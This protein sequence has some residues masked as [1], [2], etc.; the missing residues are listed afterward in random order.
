MK[1]KFDKKYLKVSLYVIF[2]VILIY[3]ATIIIDSIPDILSTARNLLT[4]AFHLLR[5]LIFALVF[6]YLLFPPTRFFEKLLAGRKHHFIKSLKKRRMISIVFCYLIVFGAIAGLMTGIYFMIGGQFSSNTT[7]EKIY[8]YI[9]K[10]FESNSFS[11]EEL[12]RKLESLNLPFFNNLETYISQGIVWIQ[13]FLT[14]LLNTFLSSVLSIGS[15]VFSLLVAFVLSI[16]LLYD[17]EYFIS[18]WNRMFFLFFRNSAFGKKIRVALRM[19]DDTFSNYVR[20]QLIE[21]LIVAV[22]STIALL[23]V[24]I[25]YAFLIGIISGLFNLVPYIG[26]L[27]G[28]VLAAILGLIEGGFWQ[29][30][31][32]IVAMVIVQQLDSNIFQPKVVGHN[33]GLHPLF[34]MV[35]IIVGGSWGG[36]FGMLVAVPILASFKKMIALW[37]ANHLE[38]SYQ[39]RDCDPVPEEE[40]GPEEENDK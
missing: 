39:I 19:I 29:M 8:D 3:L 31:W 10:Y 32:A 28:T 33:V 26:P 27:I 18:L 30:L 38:E 16:Y 9:I 22:L 1:P 25:D 12:M 15:S 37:Y 4:S 5:P 13:D 35:A 11:Q 24:G 17:T 40:K 20:G 14:H 2:T 7:L 36:L 6:A 34:I 23:I 21:A